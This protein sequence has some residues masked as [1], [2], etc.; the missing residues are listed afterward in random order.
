M[1]PSPPYEEYPPKVDLRKQLC[2]PLPF[3]APDTLPRN[4]ISDVEAGKQTRLVLN[5]LN[6]A[7]DANDAEMFASCF[8]AT[9]AFWRDMLALTAHLRTFTTP[10]GIAAAFLHMKSPRGI[11]GDVKLTG[12]PELFPAK[13]DHVSKKN[14]AP[15]CTMHGDLLSLFGEEKDVVTM[16]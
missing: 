16:E 2:Q 15:I 6:T 8:F 4:G 14:D 12:S 5:T 7:L 9:Q 10:D 11:K 1:P 3:I 13:A